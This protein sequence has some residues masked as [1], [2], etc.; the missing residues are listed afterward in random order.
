MRP[1][2]SLMLTRGFRLTV[3]LGAVCSAAAVIAGWA[4]IP[5]VALFAPSLTNSAEVAGLSSLSNGPQTSVTEAT[6]LVS[7]PGGGEQR[8]DPAGLLELAE[9]DKAVALLAYM[10]AARAREGTHDLVRDGALDAVAMKRAEDLLRLGY[11]EHY[12]PDGESAFSELRARGIKYRLAGEN[13]ARNNHPAERTVVAAFES[14]MASEGHRANIVEAR[15][16][17]VGIAAVQSGKLW[18]YVTVFTN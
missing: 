14:L 5:E 1:I 10:N 4:P 11:F 2:P 8:P 13:L 15:F 9:G 18:L 12:G 16:Y 6:P 3:A 7:H 17:S